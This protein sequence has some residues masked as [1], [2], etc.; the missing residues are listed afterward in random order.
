MSDI[1]VWENLPKS[2]SDAATIL[3][4][5]A[6]AIDAHNADA[7]AH[8]DVGGSLQS[9]KASEIIDHLALSIVADKL[10][11]NVLA[12]AQKTGAASKT[13][14][15]WYP[16]ST[17]GGASPV[18]VF[19]TDIVGGSFVCLEYGGNVS[20]SPDGITWTDLAATFYSLNPIAF[21]LGSEFFIYRDF[22][23][24]LAVYHSTNLTSFTSTNSDL[25][26]GQYRYFFAG[27]K[28]YACIYGSAP[29]KL[30]SSTNGLN[31]T[32]ENSSVGFSIA[33]LVQ[34][35]TLEFWL[36]GAGGIIYSSVTLSSFTMEADLNLENYG[37]LVYSNGL[38]AMYGREVGGSSDYI[39]TSGNGQ[40]WEKHFGNSE[41]QQQGLIVTPVGYLYFDLDNSNWNIVLSPTGNSRSVLMNTAFAQYG[42]FACSTPT[43]TMT[44]VASD[45]GSNTNNLWYVEVDMLL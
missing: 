24:S 23:T 44:I 3:E 38:F 8:L 19:W 22:D 39:Y 17:V 4:A 45:F 26:A 34:D 40:G 32:L 25:P 28:V 20:V 41:G 12:L 13:M 16:A 37:D 1:V 15:R 33:G 30:Y 7:D 6:A 36:L 21:T 29:Y 10:E 18:G 11:N 31:F 2:Q 27:G 42:Q 9:H 35:A 5:V 43:T 14:A